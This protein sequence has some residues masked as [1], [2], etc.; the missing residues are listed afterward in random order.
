VALTAYSTDLTAPS[1][2]L[3]AALRHS[4]SRG[5]FFAGVYIL[6]CAN[7]L[8]G[9]ILLS[10][11]RDGWTGLLEVDVSV[12]VLFAC[13][14]G[15]SLMLEENRDE[16]RPSDLAVGGIFL[17]LVI[18]PIFALSWLAVTGLSLYILVFAND[19]SARRRGALIL[20]ALTVPMLWSRLLFQFFAGPI[21]EIDA[22]LAALLLGTERIGNVVAFGDGS[23]HLVV[24][25]ACSFL[26][27]TSLAFLCWVSVTQWAKHEWSPMDILWSL[28]VCT[29]VIAVNVARITLTG[30]SR[31]HYEAIHGPLGSMVLGAIILGLAVGIS[32]L[33]ARRE[34]FSRA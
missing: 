23:G 17:I 19:R 10:L 1:R 16:I 14:A 32:V 28:L 3:A 20:L 30:W 5:E 33:S 8:L 22:S 13:F 31:D 12:I 4:I 26:A 7:G 2:G 34:L 29:S 27:N 11:N 15:I 18:L 6:A 9:R 25:P 24:A 21:L